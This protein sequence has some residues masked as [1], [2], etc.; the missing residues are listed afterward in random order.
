MYHLVIFFC[1]IR[2][3]IT[4]FILWHA[5]QILVSH[6][7]FVAIDIPVSTPW[8]ICQIAA[9][10][11]C[12][13]DCFHLSNPV[14]IRIIQTLYE[15]LVYIWSLDLSGSLVTLSMCVR[16]RA[17]RGY[18]HSSRSLW[19]IHFATCAWWNSS[20]SSLLKSHT[21]LNFWLHF[22]STEFH[23][24]LFCA[25]NFDLI[26]ARTDCSYDQFLLNTT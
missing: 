22:T 3:R 23:I 25:D 19:W 15:S 10:Q 17:K 7:I 16:K 20:S 6:Y 14:W 13:S 9:M 8:W 26:S 4:A 24:L 21:S 12:H 2:V 5:E 11:F 18:M 1:P